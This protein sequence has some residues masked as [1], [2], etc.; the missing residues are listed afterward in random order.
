MGGRVPGTYA[1]R[2]YL[3]QELTGPVMT[4]RTGTLLI[5]RW[6][7]LRSNL[8]ALSRRCRSVFV[9]LSAAVPVLVCSAATDSLVESMSSAAVARVSA[10]GGCPNDARNIPHAAPI[11]I[12]RT[13]TRIRDRVPET[14]GVSVSGPD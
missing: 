9:S 6:F 7:D 10:E 3:R 13:T 14:T 5:L 11:A 12:A 8:A 4:M 2:C 1:C